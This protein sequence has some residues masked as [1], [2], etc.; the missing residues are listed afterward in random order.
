MT[1]Q[2]LHPH[3]G[4]EH[5]VIQSLEEGHVLAER[6]LQRQDADMYVEC[7]LMCD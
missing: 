1:R 3:L 4:D 7:H 6:A 5:V 2:Q